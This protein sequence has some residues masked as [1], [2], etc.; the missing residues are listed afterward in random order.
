MN[1]IRDKTAWRATAAS[2]AATGLLAAAILAICL[3]A[4]TEQTMGDAQ[5]ILY[6]HVAVAWF[7]LL[8]QIVMA[9]TGL[10]YLLRRDLA[11]DQWSQAA[12][13]VGWLSCGL[14]LV[15]GSLWAHA[16]WGAWWTWDPRLT[17]TL[18]LWLMY[19]GCLLF[20]ANLEDRHRRAR[21]GA[22]LAL[23]GTLDLPLIV[24]ATRWFRGMHPPAPPMNP[25]MRA[26]LLMSVVG[27]AAP[28]AMLLVRRRV[29]LRLEG[30]L[31]ALQQ[32]TDA[33][34]RDRPCVPS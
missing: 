33:D 25:T 1:G 23:L 11:W 8:A 30:L 31:D 22:V 16:A 15:S 26:V 34:E 2:L 14:T 5:R 32:Q 18:L 7:A 29:Q 24:L 13:E 6:V 3:V 10:A 19:S 21:L 20:R 12:A 9:G 28:L 27:F 4:P 17:A